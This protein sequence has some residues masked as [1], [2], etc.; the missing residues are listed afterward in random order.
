LDQLYST[1]DDGGFRLFGVYGPL[2]FNGCGSW[3]VCWKPDWRKACRSVEAF[4]R[5]HRFIARDVLNPV[6]DFLLF[7]EPVYVACLNVCRRKLLIGHCFANSNADD[8]II[9]GC[10]NAGGFHDA[11]SI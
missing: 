7:S 8:S 11:S 2:Y 10:G 3:Y 1:S 5:L 6:I 9:K 4:D